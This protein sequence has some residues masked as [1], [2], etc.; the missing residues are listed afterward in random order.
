MNPTTT[1]TSRMTIVSAQRVSAVRVGRRIRFLTPYSQG[2]AR[3]RN[4]AAGESAKLWRAAEYGP[5][6]ASSRA[7]NQSSRELSW[8]RITWPVFGGLNWR[9]ASTSVNSTVDRSTSES[10]KSDREKTCRLGG[11]GA[12]IATIAPWHKQLP[13]PSLLVGQGD[14]PSRCTG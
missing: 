3:S 1:K 7:Q 9:A 5:T 6:T 14:F 13:P 2:R 11:R 10:V 8:S 12:S 4:I